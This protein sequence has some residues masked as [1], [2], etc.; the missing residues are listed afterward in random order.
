MKTLY[1]IDSN[2]KNRFS[3]ENEAVKTLYKEFLIEP[4]SHTAHEILH[5]KYFNRK[6]I[7][8]PAG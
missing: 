1:E 2:M 5:T 4:N 6:K 3:F 7:L 8:N